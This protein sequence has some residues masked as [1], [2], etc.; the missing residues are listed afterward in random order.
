M[1]SYSSVN[2]N[3]IFDSMHRKEKEPG[4]NPYDLGYKVGGFDEQERIL[5]S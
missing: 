5:N 1:A 3:E 2:I 4:F